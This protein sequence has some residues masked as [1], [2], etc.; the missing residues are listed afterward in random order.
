MTCAWRYSV[1][2]EGEEEIWSA[3]HFDTEPKVEFAYRDDVVGCAYLEEQVMA[4]GCVLVNCSEI[5][6]VPVA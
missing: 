4:V 2:G 3:T 1:L 6:R 5:L